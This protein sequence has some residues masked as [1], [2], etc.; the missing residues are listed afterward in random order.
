MWTPARAQTLQINIERA[1]G[2]IP[3]AIKQAYCIV[4]TVSDKDDV[5]AF[6]ITVTEEPH[7]NIIKADRRSRVQDTAIT[8]EALLPDGPYNLWREGETSRRVKDLAGAF[9]QLPHLPKMLKASAILDTLVDGCEKGTFVLRLIRPDGTSR[10]WWMS[11]PDE[12]VL[13]I[14]RSSWCFRKRQN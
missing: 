4:V 1:K 5:Q 7:F 10:S 13:S 14:R 8:A 11:R 9:A 12:N 2:R 6:K 3:E